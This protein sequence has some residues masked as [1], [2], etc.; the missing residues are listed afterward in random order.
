MPKKKENIIELIKF[1]PSNMTEKDLA[2]RFAKNIILIV[3]FGVMGVLA[4]FVFGPKFGSL[5]VFLSKNRNNQ[6]NRPQAKPGAPVFDNL[7]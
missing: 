7:P 5:F 1:D 3:I 2:S 6:I 4:L